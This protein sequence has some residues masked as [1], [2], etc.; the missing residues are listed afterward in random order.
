ME[1]W[2][3][4]T[5]LGL[6]VLLL[7][8]WR[9]VRK[10]VWVTKPTLSLGFLGAALTS[11]AL[12]SGYGL[13][14]LAGLGLSWWGDVL[15]MPRESPKVFQAGIAAFLLAHVAYAVGFVMLGVAPAAAVAA[16]LV[17]TAIAVFVVRW[18][19][20]HV[21]RGMRA[22]VIAYVVVISTMVALA[23]GA[24]W[25]GAHWTVPLGAVVFYASD[26]SVARDRFVKRCIVNRL[27]GLPAYYAAQLI[28]AGSIP[29]V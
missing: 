28:L 1:L 5:A 14:V 18:L 10:V 11:G 22:P 13:A 26:L 15:L 20:P 27:W 8:E 4:F 25:Q 12:G 19:W 23:M 17:L 2:W 24:W 7:A 16:G 3:V 6:V 29:L 21:P 9:D